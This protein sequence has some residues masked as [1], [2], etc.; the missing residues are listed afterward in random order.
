ME[1]SNC[2]FQ[3]S[4]HSYKC[5]FRAA[6][7][8]FVLDLSLWANLLFQGQVLESLHWYVRR[9][10]ETRVVSIFFWGHS[11]YQSWQKSCADPFQGLSSPPVPSRSLAEPVRQLPDI[12]AA[13]LQP[14]RVNAA[15]V[16]PAGFLS[17]F[18]SFYRFSVAFLLCI[19]CTTYLFRVGLFLWVWIL[20]TAVFKSLN[21]CLIWGLVWVG[22]D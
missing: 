11:E 9:T 13:A 1:G 14:Q 7:I 17:T 18:R 19:I 6:Q 15:E 12:Q 8:L 5:F 22:L 4:R 21:A 2:C 10:F 16:P 3:F 20:C